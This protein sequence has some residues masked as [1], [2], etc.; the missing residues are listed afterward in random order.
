MSR[1][2]SERA[3]RAREEL[4]SNLPRGLRRRPP[5]SRAEK[6]LVLDLIEEARYAGLSLAEAA[7]TCGVSEQLLGEWRGER[8]RALAQIDHLEK[9]MASRLD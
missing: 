2:G 1:R 3:E 6:C 7:R 9:A 5:R 8:L 4:W